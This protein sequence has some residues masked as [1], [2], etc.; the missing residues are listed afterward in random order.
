MLETLNQTEEVNIFYSVDSKSITAYFI[1]C[2][3]L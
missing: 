3:H 1:P 2:S